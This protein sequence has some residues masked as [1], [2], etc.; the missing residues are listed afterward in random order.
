[1]NNISSLK[2]CYGCGV[3]VAACPLQIIELHENKDGFYSP[4][5][6]NPDKCVECHRC[7]DVCA[8]NYDNLAHQPSLQEISCYGAWSLDSE[9]RSSST[10][11]GLGFEIVR[12]MVSCGY[13]AI[14]VRYN[15]EKHRAE[16][17]VASTIS[18]LMDSKGSKYIP[19]YTADG[20]SEIKKGGKYVIV[21]LPC[22]ADSI[23]HYITKMRMESDCLIVDLLCHGTP[24]R[25]YWT[26][27][28]K[29]VKFQTGRVQ[30]VDFRYKGNG[31]HRSACTRVKGEKG[32]VI[33]GERNPFYQ[34]FFSDMCLNKCCHDSCKYKLVNSSAD[35]RI[36]DFWGKT[37]KEDEKGVSAVVALTEKGHRV[38]NDLMEKNICHIEP[39][40]IEDLTFAQMKDC[41]PHSIWRPVLLSFIRKGVNL[42]IVAMLATIAKVLNNPMI[43]WNKIK[44]K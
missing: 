21:G 38:L 22:Q 35:I 17:Y 6:I 7:L 1:M 33:D 39:Q 13:Q 30:D 41:A 9:V 28:L 29:S 37:Y 4:I 10:S 20:F 32:E 24:S 2:D 15:I 16:H 26:Q 42:K 5:I 3:C 40:S 43:I 12:Y 23:R 31:W 14:V 34:I 11:G 25:N 36:G 44:G 27:Y 19:S 8:F 18:E